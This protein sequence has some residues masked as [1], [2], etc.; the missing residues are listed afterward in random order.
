MKNPK[1]VEIPEETYKELLEI[2]QKYFGTMKKFEEVLK[3]SS[4][5]VLVISEKFEKVPKNSLQKPKKHWEK[6]NKA[7]YKN[8]KT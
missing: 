1:M 4:K 8:A 7:A 2:A 3:N 5:K 6:F